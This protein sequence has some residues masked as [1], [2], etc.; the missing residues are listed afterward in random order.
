LRLCLTVRYN[1]VFEKPW[2]A[3]RAFLI[4][5]RTVYMATLAF[6]EKNSSFMKDFFGKSSIVTKYIAPL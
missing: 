1:S 2:A 4:L 5:K 6:T 3:L